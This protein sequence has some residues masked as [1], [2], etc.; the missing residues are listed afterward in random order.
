MRLKCMMVE[1]GN[2]RQDSGLEGSSGGIYAYAIGIK[3]EHETKK[4]RKNE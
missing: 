1:G 4:I 3:K 2:E